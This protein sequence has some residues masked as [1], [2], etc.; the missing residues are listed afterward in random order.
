MEGR[1]HTL[2]KESCCWFC[3]KQ[4]KCDKKTVH[5]LQKSRIWKGWKYISECESF[6]MMYRLVTIQDMARLCGKSIRTM[7][8]HLERNRKKAFETFKKW[9]GISFGELE[10]DSLRRKGCYY[11]KE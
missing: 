10:N 3:K 9:S 2:D 6:E 1:H 4:V 5:V 8:R 11:I 7:Y